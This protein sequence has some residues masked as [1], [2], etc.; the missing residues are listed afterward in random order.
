MQY[1]LEYIHV[2][3]DLPWYAT[4]ALSTVIIRI[5]LTPLVIKTQKNAAIMRNVMPEMTEVQT[6]ITEARKMGNQ[7]EYAQYNQELMHL[8]K[9]KGFNPLKNML[10]PFAQ[11]P[12]FVSFFIGL[13]RM[14]NAPVESLHNGGI[15]WFTDLTLTD[16]YYVLP[17]ITCATLGL[18]IHLGTEAARVPGQESP[19]VNYFLKAL[20][21]VIFPFIM[22]FPCA[23]VV[24]WASSNFCSLIQVF[25]VRKHFN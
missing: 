6:K 9:S 11:A 1:A 5:L 2:S 10:I 3:C 15:L 22:N 7:L 20:P 23:M 24:Y 8:M 16:P 18:T 14:V 12:I 4:I 19:L 25:R 17:A 13:R 21:V